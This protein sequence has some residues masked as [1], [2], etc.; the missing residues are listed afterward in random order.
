MVRPWDKDIEYAIKTTKFR[1]KH[2]EK[3][4]NGDVVI[5]E[6][7]ILQKQERQKQIITEKWRNK[8]T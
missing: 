1:I 2:H 6:K 7:K 5:K 3:H 8:R 4:G